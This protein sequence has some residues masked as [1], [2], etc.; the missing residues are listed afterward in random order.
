MFYFYVICTRF[1]FSSAI[2][3]KSKTRSFPLLLLNAQE[4]LDEEWRS[5]LHC[6]LYEIF[7]FHVEE[8]VK[9]K[10]VFQ[11]FT[12]EAFKYYVLLAR[13][14]PALWRKSTKTAG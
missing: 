13:E 12:L 2:Q 4:S 6:G 7:G 8:S 9:G 3:V 10:P 5:Q 11:L 14:Y 1:P